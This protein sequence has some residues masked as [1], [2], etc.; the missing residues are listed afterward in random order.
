[1]LG[2][3]QPKF[4]LNNNR[5]T[6]R[7]ADGDPIP[8]YYGEAVIDEGQFYRVQRR[9][10]QNRVKKGRQNGPRRFGNLFIG[11]CRC[12]ECGGT[13]GMQTGSRMTRWRRS[14]VLRCTNAGRNFGCANRKRYAYEPLEAAVMATVH[15]FDLPTAP[16]DATADDLAV[17]EAMLDALARRIRDMLAEFDGEHR[18]WDRFSRESY[19]KLLREHDEKE[20]ELLALR[21]QVLG[22][23]AAPN[24]PHAQA[25]QELLDRLRSA[26]GPELY[27]LRASLNQAL[28][29]IIDFIDF[30]PNGDVRVCILG[31]VR[32][33]RFANGAY[34]DAVDLTGGVATTYPAEVFTRG[35]PEREQKLARLIAA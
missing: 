9:I 12:Y 32:A 14:D 23:R 15:E 31:G 18:R 30:D 21:A 20:A 22:R 10:E 29:D 27:I 4:A 11:L 28:R 13:V 33:Y 19:D 35:S 8:G 24:V 5:A 16:R 25:L 7:P 26:E 3:Y 6:G 34:V 2:E 17:A 1:V